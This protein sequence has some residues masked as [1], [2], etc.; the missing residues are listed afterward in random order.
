MRK[1]QEREHLEVKTKRRMRGKRSRYGRGRVGRRG[2]KRNVRRSVIA[3]E[4]RLLSRNRVRRERAVRMDDR[5]GVRGALRVR[6]VAAGETAV[7][8]G[9]RV[10][11]YRVH[12]T[13]ERV[14]INRRQG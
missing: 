12:G 13:I 10:V 5:R 2:N 4:M 9:L 14:W 11:Y 8:L 6:T 1:A 7:G 3:V